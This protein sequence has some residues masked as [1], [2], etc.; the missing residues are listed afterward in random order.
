MR[1]RVGVYAKDAEPPKPTLETKRPMVEAIVPLTALI[2]TRA[3]M[4]EVLASGRTSDTPHDPIW[5]NASAAHPGMWEIAD[6]HHRVARALRVGAATVPALL[7]PVPDEEPYEEPYYYFGP[8]TT[9][10]HEHACPH[11]RT[12]P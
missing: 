2:T 9:F 10:R 11:R 4:T 3:A 1:S 8:A 6:G 5:L 12:Y 7:D